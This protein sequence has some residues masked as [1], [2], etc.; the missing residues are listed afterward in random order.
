MHINTYKYYIEIPHLSDSFCIFLKYIS[1]SYHQMY[2]D[3]ICVWHYYPMTGCMHDVACFVAKDPRRSPKPT[4][5]TAY[6]VQWPC[7]FYVDMR[8][9]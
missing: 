9:I 1:W 4:L 8:L 5:C 2:P 6:S 7:I 3:V